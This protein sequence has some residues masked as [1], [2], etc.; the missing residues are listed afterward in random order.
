MSTD[1][2]KRVSQEIDHINDGEPP[3][4]KYKMAEPADAGAV[5]QPHDLK[6]DNEYSRLIGAIGK[7]A[8]KRLQAAKVLLVGLNG[9]GLEIAK[10]LVLM[11][12]ASLTI[13]DASPVRIAD[14]SSQFFLSEQDV[15]HNRAE[16]AFTKLTELNERVD[17]RIHN[18]PL[19]E[20]VLKQ[21]TVVCIAGCGS[22]SELLRINEICHRLNIAFIAT[23][24]PGLFGFVF[25]DL[26]EEFQVL[27]STGE[28]LRNGYVES[29]TRD[30]NSVVTVV[31]SKRHDLEDG[32]F[33][34]FT[35]V[36]GME[37]LN[38]KAF[39]I[40]VKGPFSFS[41]GDTSNFGA[42]LKGGFVEEVRQVK[43][44]SFKSL[45]AFFDQKLDMERFLLADYSKFDRIDQY[46]VYLQALLQYR[47]K[48]NGASPKPWNETEAAEIVAAAE[49]LKE[50]TG[51]EQVNGELV[52]K[53]AKISAGDLS[54]MAAFFGGIVAQEVIKATSGKYTPINQW[55]YFDA[56]ECLGEEVVTEA[57]A[58]PR[59]TRYDGQIAVFGNAFNEQLLNARYFLVGSGAIGCEMLKN[60]AMMGLGCGPSGHIDV[61]DMDT[62]EISNLNRQF[63]YRPWDIGKLKSETAAAAV[64]RMNPGMNI[65][66]WAVKVAAETESTYNGDFWRGLTGVCNALDNVPARLYVDQRCIFYGKSLL[67]SGTLGTKGNTQVVVPHL[68]ESY[69]SSRDPP[70]KQ[71]PVCLLHSFPNNIEHCLQWGREQAFEGHFVKNPEIVNNYLKKDNYIATLAPTLKLST[72][73]VLEDCLLKPQKTFDECIV[74]AREEFERRYDYAPRQLL[75][76][77]PLDHVDSNGVHFWSGAKRPPTPLTFDATND[78][79]LDFVVAGAFLRA[80]TLGLIESEFKPA[81][82]QAQRAHI[83]AVASKVKCPPFVPQQGLKIN[84]DE[85]AAHAVEMSSSDAEDAKVADLEKRLAAAPAKP[86]RVVDFEKDNDEN[87]HIDFVSAA[88]NLR[89]FSYNIATVDRLK[90][91]LIAGNIIPAIVTTTACVT[92]LVCI[93]LYKLFQP[94][95]RVKVD[96]FRNTFLNLAL[97]V[98]QQSEPIP[99]PQLT[100]LDKKYTL[101]DRIDIHL[102]PTATL[103]DIIDYFEREHKLT[104]DMLGVGSA[105]VFAAYQVAAAKQRKPRVFTELVQEITKTQFAPGQTHI[106]LEITATD[107]DGNDVDTLP[108]IAFWLTH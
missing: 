52:K 56:L 98:V 55:L 54:P 61:T 35:E 74:W 84:T 73:E 4:K 5:A 11:G 51:V 90:S 67:E 8:L 77:F 2:K 25:V 34:H 65:K 42:Y 86:M 66:A 85:K 99:P 68:T 40:T 104:V 37:E 23:D 97:P 95:V 15:G 43:K 78:L 59:N 44:M 108:D 89:A 49:A 39:K 16:K 21:F 31:D 57:D 7:D 27:D 17:M 94:S 45:A 58:A 72:L 101:W 12:V 48:H 106:M 1:S 14:L 88:S 41:I 87:F 105:L 50:V 24:I 93:E 22:K 20:E 3:N 36:H 92:G 38:G 46:H 69:G 62:I 71:T 79:H 81:D 30:V 103:A 6:F 10:N 28:Q 53:L 32:D 70:A 47:E 18:E 83:A 82:Y 26:G 102:A 63:L 64:K 19:S 60:W 91:K 80:Y 107:L 96:N 9:L 33:V 13:H 75:Y 100:Y 76:N 29:I